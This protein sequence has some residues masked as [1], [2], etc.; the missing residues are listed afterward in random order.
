LNAP[1]IIES[2]QLLALRLGLRCDTWRNHRS[3]PLLDYDAAARVPVNLGVPGEV[4]LHHREAVLVFGEKA[5]NLAPSHEFASGWEDDAEAEVAFV[6][7]DFDAEEIRNGRNFSTQ[8]KYTE[9]PTILASFWEL[10][11]E[12]LAWHLNRTRGNRFKHYSSVVCLHGEP[13]RC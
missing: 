13:Y 5:Q 4:Y 9:Q 10:I 2:W 8:S 6:A 3:P 7:L 1:F 12:L 11:C